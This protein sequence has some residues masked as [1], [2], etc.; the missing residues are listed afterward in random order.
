MVKCIFYGVDGHPQR[1]AYLRGTPP[2]NATYIKLLVGANTNMYD[3]Y[4]TN[5]AAY[6]PPSY[7][8]AY[9]YGGPEMNAPCNYRFS[10][11]GYHTGPSYQ[12]Q[13]ERVPIPNPV[14]SHAHAQSMKMVADSTPSKGEILTTT[15]RHFPPTPPPIMNSI[16]GCSDGPLRKTCNVDKLLEELSDEGT[17]TMIV[18]R[19]N[20]QTELRL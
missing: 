6:Q 18:F 15:L 1:V 3:F 13:Y 11:Y 9:V 19:L 14:A 16:S 20:T 2:T 10:N 17:V 4:S 7:P 8:N 5:F 12:A